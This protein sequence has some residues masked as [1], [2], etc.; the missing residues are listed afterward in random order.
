MAD[1]K[2]ERLM[3]VKSIF[4]NSHILNPKILNIDTFQFP[5]DS[6]VHWFKVTPIIDHPSNQVGY[7]KNNKIVTDLILQYPL[8]GTV[9][10]F[11]YMPTPT[12]LNII[13]DASKQVKEF[14]W[15]LPNQT[16]RITPK[17]TMVYSYGALLSK[18]KY[19]EQI[20]RR[21][22]IYHNS[23]LT[24]M[25]NVLRHKRHTFIVID[26]PDR[27]MTKMELNR[28]S[29]KMTNAWLNNFPTTAH[30]NLLELWK[31]LSPSFHSNS[32]FNK[33]P[34][35][36]SDKK[37]TNQI[38]N[39]PLNLTR[40]YWDKINLL[41]V[42][43]T[44][45]MLINLNTLMGFIEEHQVGIKGISPM[46][47]NQFQVKFLAM[48]QTFINNAAMTDEELEKI[49]DEEEKQDEKGINT[50]TVQ[51]VTQQVAKQDNTSSIKVKDKK[52]KE[53]EVIEEEDEQEEEIE[54]GL[55]D[56]NDDVEEEYMDDTDDELKDQYG[57]ELNDTIV[58]N[59]DISS[60]EDMLKEEYKYDVI[61]TTAD[62]M[63][64]NKTMTK[65]RY[66]GIKQTLEEQKN[67][68]SP[69]KDMKDVKLK[70]ILD[71]SKDD[72]SIPE[73]DINVTDNP[74][75]LDKSYNKV[76]NKAINKNY[77]KKQ[78]K[79]DIIRSV[80]S[81]QNSQVLVDDYQVEENSSIMGDIETHNIKLRAINNNSTSTIKINLPKVDPETGTMKVSSNLYKLRMQKISKIICKVDSNKVML[82]TYYGKMSITKARSSSNNIGYW[83]MNTLVKKQEE[84][85]NLKNLVLL[86]I[87]NENTKL[88]LDYSHFA[89]YV[90]S[91]TYGKMDFMF[92]Y[93][94][95]HKLL[96]ELTPEGL[97]DIEEN[98]V[99]VGVS[100]KMPIIMDY[101]NRLFRLTKENKFEEIP[102]IYATLGI[103]RGAAPMEF[104]S[105]KVLKQNIPVVV[106]LSYY[107]GLENLIKALGVNYRLE[108]KRARID[109]SKEYIIP[110]KDTYLILEKK[111]N[112]SDLILAGLN[113][114]LSV[115]KELPLR[116]FNN[117]T[118]FN[119]IFTRMKLSLMYYNEIKLLETMFID[120]MSLTLLKQLKEPTNFKGLLIRAAELLE[121]D[122]FKKKTDVSNVVIK[123]HERIAGMMY[124]ELVNA[125]KENDNKA[126]F[127]KSKI[128]V[129]PYGIINKITEDSTT[130]LVDDLNPMAFIKQSE[131]VSML[132]TFGQSKD[133]MARGT[134]GMDSSEIGI[135]SEAT[136]D[137]SDVGITAYLTGN[138]N[139]D[140]MR[141]IVKE[142]DNLDNWSSLL[143]TPGLLMPFTTTDDVKRSNFNNIMQSHIIPINEM[144][145]PYVRTG[146]E[147]IIPLKAGSKFVIT[148]EDNG[149]VTKLTKTSMEVEYQKQGKKK[150]KI[151]VWTTKEESEACYTH[152][153]V[154]N[155]QEGDKFLKDDSLIY[156]SAFFQPDM[157]NPR[158]VIYKQ[159]SM[160]NVALMEDAQTY[161]DSAAMSMNV[162]KR[163]G[164]I[165]T[166]VKSIVVKAEDNILNI[167]Q[168]GDVLT[169]TSS[170]FTISDAISAPT[171]L[172]QEALQVLEN[173]KSNA[174][175]AKL[176]GVVDKIV[177]MYNCELEDMSKTLREITEASNTRLIAS[178]GHTG[179]VNSGY[180]VR[181]MSLNEGEVEIKIYIRVED[182]MGIGDKLILGSQLKC[183]I[184]DVYDS[185]MEGE[186]GT[187]VEILFS[188]RAISARIVN[189]AY[190]NGTTSTVLEQ[191]TKK[192]IEMYFK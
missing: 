93:E 176:K 107:I 137:S 80:Y 108:V 74:V 56:L 88:P 20:L 134:R 38:G 53:Q 158:R 24:L 155:F 29:T 50:A 9:G 189:S 164:T 191:L 183:T 35:Y 129:N 140:N 32:L 34:P 48:L 116:V 31:F 91:F 90:K 94:E 72:M 169:P 182:N 136:R 143:S 57:L 149:K 188:S 21:W 39:R 178:T 96:P 70:D 175:K 109:N 112:K 172:N 98:G 165:V 4:R 15:L 22:N 33:L 79:K 42:I 190:L 66:N 59:N 47:F 179:R 17:V 122:D 43:D 177:I 138:P 114:I 144:R 124:K 61:S 86:T 147:A 170:L 174:P 6:V 54:E 14:K 62:N 2:Y 99:L 16:L 117:R 95:R 106:L 26:L 123:G 135:L 36:V 23:V 115:T 128:T 162:S 8:E 51:N 133:A 111:F 75:I 103:D 7:L 27:L 13:K 151:A 186:D 131:D 154:P 159:G 119:V 184:G 46:N 3:R 153:M 125:V 102:D 87:T 73:T 67:K 10:K 97:V 118:N 12:P 30:F 160:V 5:L 185:T 100:G 113:G 28:Y 130:V 145:V 148:A 150:Y 77:L 40:D 84:D 41:L 180:S 64:A 83:L 168:S 167:V 171:A 141:G 163:L 49:A 55:P 187:P 18:Y 52:E 139:I 69:Y 110:F 152:V 104:V 78:Y 60:V 192:A 44:K 157:F 19:P 63:L 127:S 89:R 105:I 85:E 37:D 161:E 132:G 146:Y 156:D 92:N 101:K 76:V 120:P 11:R 181:G 71:D 68:P 1:I 58:L 121:N 25:D 81:L 142:P 45:C 173:I 82:S 166:K 65:V 126:F